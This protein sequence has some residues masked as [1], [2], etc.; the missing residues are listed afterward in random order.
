MGLGK[1]V[2]VECCG[3]FVVAVVEPWQHLKALVGSLGHMWVHT[4]THAHTS[5][6]P[7]C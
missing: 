1:W 2:R 5:V 6:D 4:R 7:P 3:L